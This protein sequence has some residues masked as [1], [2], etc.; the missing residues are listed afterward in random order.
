MPD[1]DAGEE[2]WEQQGFKEYLLCEQCDN[3]KLA[4]WEEH[5]TGLFKTQMPQPA[6]GQAQPILFHDPDYSSLKLFFLSVLWRAGV[7][8]HPF[9]EHVRLGPHE[10]KIRDMLFGN[11]PG[12]PTDYGCVVSLLLDRGQLL[13]DVL[14]QPTP[15]G[16]QDPEHDRYLFVFGG[17]LFLY[18]ISK[19]GLIP[20]LQQSMLKKDGTLTIVP[21]E[22]DDFAVLRDLRKRAAGSVRNPLTE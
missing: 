14:V 1:V 12:D 18:F 20:K 4:A 9:Y 6:A 11:I 5:A 22:Y 19:E 2:K 16:I 7:S 17:F 21:A 13:R 15:C 8:T 3:E 10:D